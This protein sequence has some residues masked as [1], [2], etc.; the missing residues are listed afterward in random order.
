MIVGCSWD[1]PAV[2]RSSTA[3]K[4]YDRQGDVR[5]WS[6]SASR[7]PS[8]EYDRILSAT[9]CRSSVPLSRTVQSECCSQL[10]E[11]RYVYRPIQYIET[12]ARVAPFMQPSASFVIYVSIL[13][14][15]TSIGI[16]CGMVENVGVA[17]EISLIVVMH[18]QE[19]CNCADF[20][21]FPIFRPPYWISGMC[22][23]WFEGAI[24]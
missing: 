3:R 1:Q 24:L 13:P 5:R 21:V 17:V 6:I 20:K 10:T 23:I 16:V 15:G 9:V 18:A 8:A 19:S 22:Q 11:S 2:S 7:I 4:S 14:Q 12:N